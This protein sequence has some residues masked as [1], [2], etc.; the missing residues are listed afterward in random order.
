MTL[1]ELN[2]RWQSAIDCLGQL[3]ADEQA[4]RTL[5]RLVKRLQSN[6]SLKTEVFSPNEKM[7]RLAC[8]E[9]AFERGEGINEEEMDRFF[10]SLQ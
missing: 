1:I 5:E 9:A 4:V 8:A 10:D 6:S 7:E 3:E 2:S